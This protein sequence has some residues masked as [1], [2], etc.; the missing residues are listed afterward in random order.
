MG[1][2]AHKH[3]APH[4]SKRSRLTLRARGV[5]DNAGERAKPLYLSLAA[6]QHDAAGGS[7]SVHFTFSSG[8]RES[9]CRYENAPDHAGAFIFLAL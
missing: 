3:F 6:Q 1:M 9:T 4:I 8:G 5:V 7:E 2:F